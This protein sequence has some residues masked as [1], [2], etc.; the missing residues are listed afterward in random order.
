M[1]DVVIG[2][3][4]A[5][6]LPPSCHFVIK[7]EHHLATIMPGRVMKKKYYQAM[8]KF[9]GSLTTC[10]AGYTTPTSAISTVKI[11]LA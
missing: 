5:A 11:V 4:T 1:T 3:T 9:L 6:I 8:A 7:A 10:K 2:K